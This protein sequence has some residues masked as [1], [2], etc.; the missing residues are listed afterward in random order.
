ME[1]VPKVKAKEPITFLSLENPAG[2]RET[3]S[4]KKRL[5][6]LKAIPNVVAPEPINYFFKQNMEEIIPQVIPPEQKLNLLNFLKEKIEEI[7]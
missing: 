4:L 5:R 7:P 3:Q 2:L 1:D 6:S